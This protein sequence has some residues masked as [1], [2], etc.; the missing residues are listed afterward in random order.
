MAQVAL[1]ELASTQ[2]SMFEW[3]LAQHAIPGTAGTCMYAALLLQSAIEQFTPFAACVCGGDGKGDG[4]YVDAAGVHHGHYWVEATNETT[5]WVVDITGDQFGEPPVLVME[6]RLARAR[7]RRGTQAVI[8][9]HV[10][11][12]RAEMARDA[13]AEG[14]QRA[15]RAV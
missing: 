13:A 11:D 2:R 5:R 3:M 1:H 15:G 14:L 9:E 4:G 8:D 7:Y 6:K 12:T 10:R